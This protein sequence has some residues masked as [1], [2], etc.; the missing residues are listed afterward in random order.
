MPE[1]LVGDIIAHERFGI[2]L[3]LRQSRLLE[4][5]HSLDGVGV[6]FGGGNLVAHRFAGRGNDRSFN[7]SAPR[8][9]AVG[10]LRG[11]V[12]RFVQHALV[13][14][15]NNLARIEQLAGLIRRAHGGTASA[16]RAGIAIQELLPG[17]VLNIRC[18]ILRQRFVFEVNRLKIVLAAK[19]GEIH[20]GQ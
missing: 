6:Y 15:D 2:H 18:P 17:Q 19:I 5:E 10:F 16:V 4:E 12:R 7:F 11:E 13:R 3:F 9:E 8:F 14:S 20:I 1:H